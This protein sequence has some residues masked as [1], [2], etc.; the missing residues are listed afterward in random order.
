MDFPSLFWSISFE[1]WN[2]DPLLVVGEITVNIDNYERLIKK[3]HEDKLKKI[4]YEK[5]RAEYLK[6][7]EEEEKRNLAAESIQ[8]NE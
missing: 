8:R 5:K 4:E 3:A 6:K 1:S 7:K 2:V